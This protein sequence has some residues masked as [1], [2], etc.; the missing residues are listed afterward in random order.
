MYDTSCPTSDCME[1]QKPK[2]QRKNST[3]INQDKPKNIYKYNKN[4]KNK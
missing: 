2:E 1:K 3:R 4:G